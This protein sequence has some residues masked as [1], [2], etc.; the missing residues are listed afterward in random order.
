MVARTDFYSAKFTQEGTGHQDTE[1]SYR[2][3]LLSDPMPGSLS[4]DSS[5][6]GFPFLLQAPVQL[7]KHPLG[8]QEH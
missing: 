7:P 1:P 8:R 5:S 6:A 2:L 4:A 3:L